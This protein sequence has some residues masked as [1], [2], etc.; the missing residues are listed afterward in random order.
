MQQRS[1]TGWLAPSMRRTAGGARR[2]SALRDGQGTVADAS[3]QARRDRR[4]RAR[5]AQPGD[6]RHRSRCPMSALPRPDLPPGPHR[7]L[8]D[9]L[10]DLH[11]RAGWPSLRALAAATGVSHTTV[12]KVFSSPALPSWGTL[13]LLVEAM[14][15]DGARFHDLWVRGIEAHRRDRPCCAT[16]RRTQA[17]AGRRTTPPRDRHRPPP[18]HRRG[19]H[20]QD[21]ARHHRRRVH[22]KL[23]RRGALPAALLPG[24]VDA[25]RPSAPS[26]VR[27]RRRP[28]AP[29]RTGPAAHPSSSARSVPAPRAGRG[30]RRRP[31]GGRRVVSSAALQLDRHGARPPGLC[32][33][34]VA[35][36]R[37]PALGRRRDP[38]PR[39]STW[40][41]VAL[42]SP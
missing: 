2:R 5:P 38:G 25:D 35:A 26:R 23:R 9:A 42:G 37:R 7:E 41:T 11:H 22:R 14:D 10:H 8:V 21:Q 24:A 6:R 31:S 30:G 29:Y 27:R 12:S 33:T 13:E 39:S 3:A 15:G 28:V 4:P 34:D 18:R 40:S 32:A 20:R 36:P 16:D 19:R 17:R 1:G